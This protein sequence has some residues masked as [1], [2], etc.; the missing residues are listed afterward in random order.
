[1]EPPV[2][3]GRTVHVTRQGLLYYNS[4]SNASALFPIEMFLSKNT[5]IQ[6]RFHHKHVRFQVFIVVTMMSAVLWDVVLCSLLEVYQHFA[7]TDCMQATS[8][9]LALLP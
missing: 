6:H 1:M 5:K 2:N 9:L 7:G 3:S 8:T 4:E